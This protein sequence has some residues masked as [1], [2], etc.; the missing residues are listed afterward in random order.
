MEKTTEKPFYG[1]TAFDS[2]IAYIIVFFTSGIIFYIYFSVPIGAILVLLGFYSIFSYVITT[3]FISPKKSLDQ[4]KV[5]KLNGDELI[6][7]VGCGLGRATMGVA[8]QLKNGKII[9]VDIW[10]KLEIPGNSAEKAYKNAEIEGVKDK[11][12]FRYGDAFNLPFDDEKFDVVI[13]SGLI[14]SFHDD[15]KKLKVMKELH[16]VLK[17]NG[18]FLMREPIKHLKSLIFL[19][20]QLLMIRLPSKNHWKELLEITGFDDIKFYPH[21][22]SGSFKTIKP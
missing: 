4:S 5:L 1:Y 18:I 8:K 12:E 9:G 22:I 7:D 17:I 21:R 20:P 16:R 15:E 2:A 19:T 10:D 13:C 11:V 14:T 6:L 3:Y